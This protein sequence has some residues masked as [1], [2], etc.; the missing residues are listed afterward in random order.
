MCNNADIPVVGVRSCQLS[1]SSSGCCSCSYL[2]PWLLNSHNIVNERI[3]YQKINTMLISYL[4]AK[5]YRLVKARIT[6]Y[7]STVLLINEVIGNGYFGSRGQRPTQRFSPRP[8][9]R[10]GSAPYLEIPLYQG[11]V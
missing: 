6:A 11:V 7:Q 10:K 2:F 8:R 4:H 3:N 5:Y 1:E 9:L